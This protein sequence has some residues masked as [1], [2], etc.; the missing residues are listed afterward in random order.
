MNFKE[1]AKEVAAAQGDHLLSGGDRIRSQCG[2]GGHRDQVQSGM[3]AGL[4][5]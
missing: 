1:G 5:A 4:W 2:A 3:Q